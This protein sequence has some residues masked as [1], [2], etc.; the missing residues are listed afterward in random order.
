MTAYSV[1]FTT[2]A[3]RIVRVEADDPDEAIEKADNEVG[4]VLCH[5]CA[6]EIDLAGV[7]EPVV[8][9]DDDKNEVA[10]EDRI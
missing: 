6:G 9:F 5:Q 4:C 10:W 1:H 8:V 3:S 2:P 7:W